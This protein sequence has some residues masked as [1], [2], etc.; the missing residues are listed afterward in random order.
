MSLFHSSG[1][2]DNKLCEYYKIFPTK[3]TIKQALY[4]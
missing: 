3:H 2:S 1:V 4:K